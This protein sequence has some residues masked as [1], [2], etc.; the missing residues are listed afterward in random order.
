MS[1]C[2]C[3]D[4]YFVHWC[5]LSKSS[6]NIYWTNECKTNGMVSPGCSSVSH[7][8]IWVRSISWLFLQICP[9]QSGG[10]F[11]ILRF[12]SP[13]FRKLEVSHQLLSLPEKPG[14]A[15]RLPWS[16]N[17]KQL[18][19]D[20]LAWITAYTA[21]NAWCYSLLCHLSMDLTSLP[22]LLAHK[23]CLFR[24]YYVLILACSSG[25]YPWEVHN[26]MEM[27]LRAL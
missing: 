7:P 27:G 12:S 5:I 11:L 9:T 2:G 24:N 25:A 16:P 23:G 26:L 21:Q 20:Y 13:I 6:V 18:W 14:P 3:R 22:Q 1:T 4:F 19:S 15:P 17:P 10:R 8:W